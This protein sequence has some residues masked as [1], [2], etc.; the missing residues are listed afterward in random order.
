[1]KK[2]VL[3]TFLTLALS[4]ALLVGC[5]TKQESATGNEGNES[6]KE[7]VVNVYT[8]RHYDADKELYKLFTEET[9]ITVN[10]VEGKDDELIER[11]D[12]EGEDTEADVLIVA[13][14]GRLHRAKSQDLLQ[15]IESEVLNNNIPEN[16]R[17]KD[18]EWYGLTK[19]GRVIVY[20]K[21]RVNPSELSTYEDLINPKWNGKILVRSSSN[22]YNQ[23]LLASFI[24]INGEEKA[25]EWAKGLVDNMARE[26]KGN[27][28]DQAKAV[29]AG[30]GDIAIMNT[31]YLGKLLNSSDPEE[32]KVGEQVSVFFPN[33]DTTGTHINVSGGGV[34]KNANNKENAIKFIEFLSNEKAQSIFANANYEYPA[35]PNVEPSELLKSWGEFKTQDISLNKLGENNKRAVE[36]FNEIGWK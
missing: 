11:L 27:D 9:G 31:Y 32:V 30:E 8:S 26:P 12:R 6:N 21:D 4:I 22:T 5:T 14:A 1:M 33:Q 13:D 28:R 2:K 23:S 15:S 10:V 29:V 34:T 36:I 19:R 16:L 17:D 20:S 3:L 18:N 35:N 7:G 25:K 24:E